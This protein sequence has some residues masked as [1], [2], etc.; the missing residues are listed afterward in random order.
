MG[1]NGKD[2]YVIFFQCSFL[3]CSKIF[4]TATSPLIKLSCK[5]YLTRKIIQFTRSKTSDEFIYDGAE[6]ISGF[7]WTGVGQQD[8]PCLLYKNT[9]VGFETERIWLFHIV[10]SSLWC[11]PLLFFNLTDHS[12]ASLPIVFGHNETETPIIS[13]QVGFYKR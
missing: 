8:D 2:R 12:G 10:Y 6:E 7:V 13:Q 5:P 3:T 4:L 1:G 9:D 11:S